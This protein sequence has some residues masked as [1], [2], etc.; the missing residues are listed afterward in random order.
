MKKYNPI[1]IGCILIAIAYLFTYCTPAEEEKAEV[2]VD[3]PEIQEEATEKIYEETEPTEEDLK[4]PGVSAPGETSLECTTDSLF[5]TSPLN[6]DDIASIVALGNMHPP[7][8]VF[9][10]DHIYFFIN[11]EEGADRTHLV[12]LYSPGDLTV[13]VVNAFEHVN[14][15]ITDY[16]VRLQPCEEITVV[17]AHVTSLS[18]DIFGDTS[19]FTEWD[20]DSEYTTGGET[21]RMWRKEY[22]IKVESGQVIGAAGRNPGQWA[23]DLGV[24]DLNQ[25][26]D[27]VANPERW[28]QTWYLHA[29]DPLTCFREGE[30]LEQSVPIHGRVLQIIGLQWHI[31]H[32]SLSTG[33]SVR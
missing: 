17:F 11:R 19:D 4:S 18:E 32:H 14:A 2:P 5:T 6:L 25:I 20:L 33:Y 29:I 27:K 13:R 12:P 10:T 8:H 21:Y 7:S 15:G 31:S 28:K 9:P 1:Y 16:S 22:N 3:E 30:L 24:Y 23:L 26:Q